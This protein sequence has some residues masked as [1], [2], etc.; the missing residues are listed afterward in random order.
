M[1]TTA[2]SNVKGERVN[3]LSRRKWN[4][5]GFLLSVWAIPTI[6]FCMLYVYVNFNSVMLAFKHVSNDD[7]EYTWAGFYNFKAFIDKLAYD[8]SLE[9]AIGNSIVIYLVN[10]L[11]T[12]PIQILIAFFIYKRIYG[13]EVFKIVLFLPQV[14]ASV[15]WVMLF[16]YF[17]D[18]GMP[19]VMK[20]LG[21]ESI[22][23][24]DKDAP[25]GFAMML[26]YT[27]WIGLGGAMLVYC[28]TM[29]R[30]PDSVIEA[31]KLDGMTIMQEFVYL[32]IPLVYPIL[33]VALV[34]SV[35]SIFTNQLSMYIFFKET[36]GPRLYTIG[37]YLFIQIIGSS[38][39]SVSQYPFAAAGGILIT[40]VVA[41]FTFG[42]RWLVAKL[43]PEVSY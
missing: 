36:A 16:R 31:G 12:T 18:Y 11:I 6:L 9:Y 28:G 17:C 27:S 3:T 7:F 29:S 13:T 32:I 30:I 34:T 14:I 21:Q 41:P 39:A 23:L 42:M 8:P 5:R 15:I 37:Y 25:I 43:D 2:Q 19:E 4:E 24:L 22:F 26:F 1:K 40:L 35:P 33:S 10:M 20:S 38:T